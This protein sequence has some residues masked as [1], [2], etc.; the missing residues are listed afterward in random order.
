MHELLIATKNQGKLRE[1]KQLLKGW[2]LK[3]TSLAD[4]PRFPEII[5]DGDTFESN[6]VKKAV[7]VGK[8]SKTLVM[9][10]DSGLEVRALGGRPGIHS[11]RFAAEN[12]KNATDKKNNAKL[13]HLLKDVPD[14]KRQARYR[15]CIAL[16]DGDRVIDVVM[17][18]CQGKIAWEERGHN[19]FG[20]DPVFLAPRQNKTFGELPP[21]DK[22][23]ISHRARALQKIKRSLRCYLET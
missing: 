19:G 15:C 18:T 21:E 4:H 13:L 2:D 20:Y 6:A 17:G 23:R 16:C 10:E 14:E 3:I 8:R 22:D 12:G 11:A 7:T 9:G 1:I 5:E